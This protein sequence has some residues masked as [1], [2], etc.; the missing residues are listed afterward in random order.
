MISP[1]TQIKERLSIVDVVSGYVKLEKAGI[2]FKARCPFHSEKTPSFFVSADRGSYHCFG[3]GKGG[4]IFSFVQEIEGLDFPET[5]KLLAERAGVKLEK[6]SEAQNEK[7]KEEEEIYRAIEEA[8]KY[9][10]HELR[11]NKEVI[12]YLK[13]RG[14]T[15]E[16]AKKFRIGYAP[17]GW[18]NLFHY[19]SDK[20]IS[21]KAM[22]GAGLII[23]SEKPTAEKYYDRF[24][25]RIMFPIASSNGKIVAFSGR[26]FET[27]D[28][29]TSEAKYINSP[30]TTL[31]NKSKILF[32]Y[33]K[34]KS[35]ILKSGRCIIVE[36]QMDLCMAHQ[37]GFTDTVAVSGT[38]LTVDHLKL[39]KRF[40]D[41]I[42]LSFDSDN[43]GVSAAKR[44]AMI[45]IESGMDVLSINIEGAKDPA[46][47]IK[48]NAKKWENAVGSAM[49]FVE[50]LYLKE[51][52]KKPNNLD[53]IK[54][55]S[56]EIIPF[57]AR[58]N[59]KIEQE[60]FIKF[61]SEKLSVPDNSVR[62]MVRRAEKNVFSINDES[63][64]IE[65]DKTGMIDRIR[66][67]IIGGYLWSG[68][69]DILEKYENI[70]GE[71]LKSEIEE[72]G[73]SEAQNLT[74]IAELTY[75]S[76]D[77][78]KN[79]AKELLISLEKELLENKFESLQV[80]LKISESEKDS[81]RGMEILQECQNIKK[82]IEEL[83]MSR[84]SN[85]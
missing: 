63:Q 52:E 3:C 79:D 76:K 6:Y 74:L 49:P 37:S 58:N 67:K 47:I 54:Y 9:F 50:F 44:S 46:E 28:T 62:E 32:G 23:K 77:D 30:E 75:K 8:T 12:E 53:L 18:R 1:V 65:K 61:L 33:D 17:D 60:H 69:D 66:K 13:N 82:R 68:E 2:H 14:L 72:I 4:D 57:V 51:S 36:G 24:R 59:N 84:I 70:T 64:I 56:K 31:Y 41:K 40:T 80:E 7:L 78:W 45:A 73:E 15:G 27:G 35:S 11:G 22:E 16:T 29:K 20:K 42:I 21:T 19:L 26:I 81:K 83:K 85:K 5:L 71:K 43:A 55:V 48:E 34:A 25:S 38:A 10:E 39:I